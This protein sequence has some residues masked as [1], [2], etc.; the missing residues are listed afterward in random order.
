MERMDLTDIRH[1]DHTFDAIYCSHVLEHIPDDRKALAEMHRVLRPGGWAMLQVPITAAQTYEDPTIVTPEA[2]L[3]RFGQWDHVRLCG[4][5]YAD[6]MRAAGFVVAVLPT[7]DVVTDAE[8][9]QMRIQTD[10]YIFYCR[11][12]M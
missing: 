12:A 7:A 4:L 5:D 11:K 3:Q 6:R 10:R 2:R 9:V 1:P 8:C